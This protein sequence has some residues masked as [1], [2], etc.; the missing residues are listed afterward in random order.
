MYIHI[1]KHIHTHNHTCIHIYKHTHTQ[2]SYG[3]A[4]SRTSFVFP[5]GVD[6][7][8]VLHRYDT[9]SLRIFLGIL[10][11][12]FRDNAVMSCSRLKRPKKN[13]STLEDGR[14]CC[15]ETSEPKQPMRQRHITDEPKRQYFCKIIQYYNMLPIQKGLLS[16]MALNTP[17]QD[18][19][20][21]CYEDRMPS[22]HRQLFG[23]YTAQVEPSFIEKELISML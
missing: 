11:K 6:E 13:P 18:F 5:S 23:I 14:L 9:A 1:H 12:T 8:S 15:Q 4:R 21:S 16:D 22:L 19:K 7:V 10:L 2:N 17:V 20:A 3:S